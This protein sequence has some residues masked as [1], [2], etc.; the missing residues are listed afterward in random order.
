MKATWEE[1]D[2][3]AGVQFISR[4]GKYPTHTGIIARDDDNLMLIW[5]INGYAFYKS[6]SAACI[7]I[8]MNERGFEPELIRHGV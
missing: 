6:T 3:E 1:R 2:I 4:N 7:A 8:E 5:L